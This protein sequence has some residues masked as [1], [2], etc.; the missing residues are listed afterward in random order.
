M[1]DIFRRIK[2]IFSNYELVF[3][4]ASKEIKVRY[5]SPFLG[6]LWALLVPLCVIFTFKI[7]FSFF[8]KIPL[9]RYPFFIFLTTAVFPWNFFSLSLSNSVLSIQEN[10]NLIKKI[11]FPREIIPIS[12]ILANLINF[13]LTVILMLPVFYLFGLHFDAYIVILPLVI[14]I[15]LIFVIGVSLIFSSLQVYFRDVKY[16]VEILLFVWFYITPIFYP[17]DL[18]LSTSKLLFKLYMLNPLTQIVTLYRIALLQGYTYELP[19]GL[20]PIWLI[21]TSTVISLITLLLGLYSFKRLEVRFA[22]LV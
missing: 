6:F 14:F 15:E 18:V 11:Y 4:L 5:K 20:T 12:I 9:K 16:I 2:L 7:I 3:K 22:D 13:I 8:I 1:V 19:T 21:I 10:S 17:L